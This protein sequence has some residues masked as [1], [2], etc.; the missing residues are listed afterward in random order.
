MRH[1]RVTGQIGTEKYIS[2]NQNEANAKYD[3]IDDVSAVQHRIN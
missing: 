1:Y 3:A 2:I